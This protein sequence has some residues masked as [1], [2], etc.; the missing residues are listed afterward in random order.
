M[1]RMLDDVGESAIERNQRPAFTGCC[2]EQPIV[3]NARELLVP[4]KDY[5]VARGPKN[6]SD[7]IGN[8]LIELHSRHDYA[9]GIG[10]IASRARSAA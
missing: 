6:G 1:R 10:T 3:R 2:S 4:S 9:A 7:R 5:V 8:V